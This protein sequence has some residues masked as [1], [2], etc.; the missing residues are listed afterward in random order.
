MSWLIKFEKDYLFF[1]ISSSASVS[2]ASS[3]SV[4]NYFELNSKISTPIK[5]CLDT[6]KIK[7]KAAA[8]AQQSSH[9]KCTLALQQW[10]QRSVFYVIA[11]RIV[12]FF[13]STSPH[14]FISLNQR[15][16]TDVRKKVM[17][18]PSSLFILAWNSS[19]NWSSCNLYSMLLDRPTLSLFSSLKS[20]DRQY[21]VIRKFHLTK[22]EVLKLWKG[23][24][25]VNM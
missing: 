14:F 21:Y 15:F 24:S 20:V 8:H 4:M 6:K 9:T 11:K 16:S 5:L 7:L 13:F 10:I 23:R 2:H 3:S 19:S 17:L 1:V 25:Y 18:V 22:F 12:F